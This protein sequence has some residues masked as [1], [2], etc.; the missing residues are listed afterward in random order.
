M[1]TLSAG[2]C[3]IVGDATPIPAVVKMKKPNPKPKS[4]NVAFHDEWKENWYEPS[5]SDI[6][7][8]WKKD[9]ETK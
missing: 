5:F 2:Q 4:E 8:R 9:T 7:N 1:P 6:I 3:L